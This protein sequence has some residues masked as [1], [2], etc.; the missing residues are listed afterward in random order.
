[1]QQVV[2]RAPS[3]VEIGGPVEHGRIVVFIQ[4]NYRRMIRDAMS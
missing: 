4:R 1:M 3:Q 2:D